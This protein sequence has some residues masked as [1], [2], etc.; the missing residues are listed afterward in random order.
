MMIS[1]II[2][3]IVA[4][5]ILSKLRRYGTHLNDRPNKDVQVFKIS[6]GVV[7]VGAEW[8]DDNEVRYGECNV[9]EDTTSEI[10]VVSVNYKTY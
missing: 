10:K 8:R 1:K 9:D 3:V 7:I 5:S 4:P 2:F 6:C